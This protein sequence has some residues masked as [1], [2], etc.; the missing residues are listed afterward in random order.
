ML[1][2]GMIMGGTPLVAA[3][4]APF[5]GSLTAR[6]RPKLLFQIGIFCN[7]LIFFIQ[8]APGR[9]GRFQLGFSWGGGSSLWGRSILC[10]SPA[11][12]RTS[13]RASS[14][15]SM[16]PSP[17]PDPCFGPSSLQGE[18]PPLPEGASSSP[19]DNSHLA[20]SS[21]RVRLEGELLDCLIATRFDYSNRLTSPAPR[22]MIS[23]V[24]PMREM[25]LEGSPEGVLPSTT[26]FTCPPK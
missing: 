8:K 14:L 1:W 21:A 19:I 20:R 22:R 3:F 7:G 23:G 13:W 9:A 25:T 6:I 17:L 10:S 26:A 24:S 12:C 4:A 5:W 18:G 15:R 11:F 2:I 16:R